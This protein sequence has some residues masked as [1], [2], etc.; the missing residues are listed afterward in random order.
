M[1][2]TKIISSENVTLREKILKGFRK[3]VEKVY[4]NARKNGEELV[5]ADKDGNVIKIKP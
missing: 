2:E 5:V 1:E 3:A 4:E